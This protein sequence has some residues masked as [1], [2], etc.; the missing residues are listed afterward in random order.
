MSAKGWLLPATIA[1]LAVLPHLPGLN[2]DFGRSLLTQMVIAA[3]F[4]MR[5]TSVSAATRPS[6]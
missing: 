6:T 2:A 3:V 1:A 5:C 4:A